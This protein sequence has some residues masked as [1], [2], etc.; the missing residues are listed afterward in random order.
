MDIAF[1]L[2]I[3]F[4]PVFI[5]RAWVGLGMPKR[6]AERQARRHAVEKRLQSEQKTS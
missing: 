6:R 5:W 4:L 1:I 2:A 3:L